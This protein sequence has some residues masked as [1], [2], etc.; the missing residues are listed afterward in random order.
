MKRYTLILAMTLLLV[1]G[2]TQ[3]LFSAKK[4]SP[5]PLTPA[6]S[7]ANRQD[8]SSKAATSKTSDSGRSVTSKTT[9]QTLPSDRRTIETTQ[10]ETA[11][12]SQ[13]PSETA[14][15][16]AGI[17]MDWISINHGGA[18]EVTSGDLKMGLSIAQTVAGEV[19]S[20]DLKMGLGFWYGAAGT[21]DCACPH[22]VDMDT[23]GFPTALDLGIMI[24][25]AFGG[26]PD[27]V[28]AGCPVSRGD[29]DYDGF[30]TMLDIGWMVD[31]LFAGGPGPC[32]P[33]NPVQTA[34]S[35]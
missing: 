16:A 23:D 24:G 6:S 29:F 22:Q 35:K 34:C 12:E 10:S 4:Q 1:A 8:E 11:T 5:K 32:E 7:T 14:G 21:S 30:V 25:I 15:T 3:S 17:R 20:G 27:V 18:T 19:S 13:Q 33:C 9:P 2:G 31:Y 28:D 26:E